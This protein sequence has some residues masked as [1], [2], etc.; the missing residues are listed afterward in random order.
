MTQQIGLEAVMRTADFD[1]GVARYLAGITSMNAATA[2]VGSQ[3]LGATS[4]LGGTVLAGTAVALGA[5][6]LG[7]GQAAKAF[8]NFTMTGVEE[9]IELGTQI[10]AIA[11]IMGETTEA[12]APLE[13]HISEL[14]LDKTLKVNAEE[15]ADAIQFLAKQGLDLDEIIGGAARSTVL[16]ANATGS[17]FAPAAEIAASTMKIFNKEASD[18]D[19]IL[20]TVTGVVNNSRHDIND[21][22]L[23]LA[24]GGGVAAD[25]GVTL[26]EFA[27]VITHGAAAFG[28][29]SDEGTSFKRML[30]T[31]VP[32]SERASDVMKELGLMTEDGANQFFTASG[33]LKHMSEVADIMSGA[34]SGLSEEAR[35][36]AMN[37]I[38]GTDAS[39]MATAMMGLAGEAYEDLSAEVNAFGQ[40]EESAITRTSDLGS[41]LE[42]LNDILTEIRRQS[43]KQFEGMLT[44]ITN[45]LIDLA[46]AN[47]PKV[48]AFF[49]EFAAVVERMI[50]KLIPLAEKW[51]PVILNDLL[52]LGRYLLTAAEGGGFFNQWLMGLSD[53][54][55]KLVIRIVE[56][57]Q[58]FIDFN[59]EVKRIKDAILATIKPVT[60]FILKYT[61][62]KDLLLALG[63]AVAVFL[64]PLALVIA[65]MA[66]VA[67]AIALAI[68]LIR[69]AWEENWGGI[70]EFTQATMD[71]I[72][73]IFT[74]AQEIWAIIWDEGAGMLAIII[75]KTWD[76]IKSIITAALDIINGILDVFLAVL[77]GDWEAAWQG[78]VDIAT[79]M[80]DLLKELF[81]Q[82]VDALIAIF[83]LMMPTIVEAFK[84]GWELIKVAAQEG[85]TFLIDLF[86]ESYDLL[87][88]T[89]S[90]KLDEM[91]EGWKTFW[92]GVGEAIETGWAFIVETFEG[93]WGLITDTTE[94]AWDAIS[95]FI[96]DTIDS[97]MTSLEKFSD[98]MATKLDNLATTIQETWQ[99]MV[100]GITELWDNFVT[101]VTTKVDELKTSIVAKFNEI[102]TAVVTAVTSIK[103]EAVRAFQEMIDSIVST[104]TGA[105]GALRTAAENM[106][107]GFIDGIRSRIGEAQAAAA[108]L[109]NLTTTSAET[110]LEVQ[111]PSRRYFRMAEQVVG[112]FI[113]GLLAQRH[114]LL[115][116]MSTLMDLVAVKSDLITGT[117]AYT[118]SYQ[119]PFSTPMAPVSNYS[120]V[121]RETHIGPFSMSGQMDMAQLRY[122]V[123]QW[124]RE[125]F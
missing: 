122:M 89:A 11:A 46:E 59:R 111:S 86:N 43:G 3:V 27:T 113:G 40:A 76:N 90:E 100:D 28:S 12:I 109:M 125:D 19:D 120:T 5:V 6:T 62:M 18:F 105:V 112:G 41:R 96:E 26:E 8:T 104:I 107:G 13:Q 9:S 24:M 44:N 117:Q 48:I 60:D 84:G 108:E 54:L 79:A 94:A 16:L 80:W 115:R 65:K 110:E 123:R 50:E 87:V 71:K 14:A 58:G 66:A 97:I 63:I 98:D 20:D 70:R 118:S 114:N 55:Q 73:E 93:G 85:W 32:R 124:V 25:A 92:D 33:E 31:L 39:R 34:F 88:G 116:E 36:A 95:G 81:Q 17:G 42:I 7:V 21:W 102:K 30:Q 82:S 78:I 2:G 91:I 74:K 49:G 51:L 37:V 77:E 72:E 119:T 83:E 29:G 23:A 4:A 38:F 121:N 101:T 61:E 103:D 1:A 47:G 99:S 75:Q 52:N 67:T 35:T 53:P 15:A 64:A 45:R 57:V 69:T 22:R 10:A 68:G 56:T 106:V